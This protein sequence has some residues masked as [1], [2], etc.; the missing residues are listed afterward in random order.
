MSAR[1]RAEKLISL[2][3][4][5]GPDGQPTNE[6]RNAAVF[7]VR[8]I[9]EHDMLAASPV[10]SSPPPATAPRRTAREL[11]DEIV[12]F[13]K[14]AGGALLD[15]LA[16][17]ERLKEHR[18]AKRL[19]KAAVAAARWALRKVPSRRGLSPHDIATRYAIA[20]TELEMTCLEIAAE[21]FDFT[22]D[23]E[24][25][26][27]CDEE[28]AADESKGQRELFKDIG[29]AVGWRTRRR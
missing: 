24:A 4:S 14:V 17:R 9:R 8:L 25:V 7:A 19:Q 6:A 13:A 21:L 29:G 10:P 1:E 2:A 20:Y 12:P 3:L 15:T 26:S 11:F 22:G 23:V 18:F 27:E 28:I 5:V 16:T